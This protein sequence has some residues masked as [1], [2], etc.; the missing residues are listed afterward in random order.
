VGSGHL[1]LA[2]ISTVL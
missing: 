1:T 2:E